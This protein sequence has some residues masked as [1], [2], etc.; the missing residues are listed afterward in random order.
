[1]SRAHTSKSDVA[2]PAAKK[3]RPAVQF[4]LWCEHC[5]KDFDSAE[6]NWPGR[7]FCNARCAEAAG[8][9][10]AVCAYCCTYFFIAKKE[11][12]TRK[13]CDLKC[14]RKGAAQKNAAKRAAFRC[15]TT[16][17]MGKRH[18]GYGL[19]SACYQRATIK[20]KPVGRDC[21]TCGAPIFGHPSKTYCDHACYQA[22]P[23]FKAAR[24][25]YKAQMKA[26]RVTLICATCNSKFEV[27]KTRAK[28][29][30]FC[31]P[32]C[33]YRSLRRASKEKV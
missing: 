30:R 20:S 13:Y 18:A 12:K 3:A 32:E 29:A 21:L 17:C 27:T 5:H 25:R 2:S 28:K 26:N 24:K 16:D 8:V 4:R 9:V 11:G 6:Q 22:G 10:E 19:C 14:S 1:V 33:Y 15:R 31:K 23:A 7:R